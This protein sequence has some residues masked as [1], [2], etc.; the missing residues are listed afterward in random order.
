M[1]TTI[2]R[3]LRSMNVSDKADQLASL[4]EA[5]RSVVAASE[6]G[7]EVREALVRTVR[8]EKVPLSDVRYALTYARSHDLVQV[9]SHTN[10]ITAN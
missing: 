2:T 10:E 9:N 1:T 8:Q 5:L 7:L 4:A 3:S 6:P